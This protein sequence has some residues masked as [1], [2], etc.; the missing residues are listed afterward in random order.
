MTAIIGSSTRCRRFAFVYG[1]CQTAEAQVS[2]LRRFSCVVVDGL[3]DLS[4]AFSNGNPR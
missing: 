1:Y 4:F 3:S 2:V